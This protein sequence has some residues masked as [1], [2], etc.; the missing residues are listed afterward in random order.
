[1][2]FF[3]PFSLFLQVDLVDFNPKPGSV[4]DLHEPVL[5]IEDVG[6]REVVKYVASLV[7]VDVEALFLD[8]GVR[9]DRIDVDTGAEGD[10]SGSIG[11]NRCQATATNTLPPGC[12][13]SRRSS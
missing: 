4:G 13:Y 9:R 11:L 5:V 1:V 2:S 12:S 6:I 7:V 3:C 8:K 10:R